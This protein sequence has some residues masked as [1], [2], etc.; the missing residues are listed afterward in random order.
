MLAAALLAFAQ[1]GP[2]VTA[3]ELQDRVR[4]LASDALEGRRAGTRAADRAAG[5]LAGELSRYGLEPAGLA[6]SWFQEFEIELAPEP[7]ACAL[8]VTAREAGAAREWRWEGLGTLACSATASAT[9]PVVSAGYGM[10]LESHGINEF[11]GADVGGKIVLVRRYS[12]F[13]PKAA[14]ELARA[15]EL[16]GKIRAAVEAGA[17]GVVLGTHPNDMARGGEGAIPFDAAPG[18][19]AV[20]VVVVSPEQLAE[21][22][23]LLA[24]GVPVEADL[25][26]E[27]RRPKAVTQNVLGWIRGRSE[28]AVVVGAHYDHLGYGG[29]A[30]LTPGQAAIHNG[31]DD[32]ASGTAL[33]LEVAET[34]AAGPPPE[35]SVLVAFWGAEEEGLLGSDYWVKNPTIPLERVVCNVNLD[36][37]GRLQGGAIT[38]GG[39]GTAAALAA[40][41]E[42]AR[43]QP[44]AQ[45]PELRFELEKGESAATGGSDHMSFQRV[46]I[47]ALFFFSGMHTD[48]HKPSDDWEKLDYGR[49]AVL[50][51]ATAA[52]VRELA[53]APRADLA[54]VPPPA[55]KEERVVRAGERA[56]FGSIPD[57]AAK[58]EGGGMQLAGVSPGGPAEKAGLRAGDVI[59]KV[60]TVAVADIYDF[61]DALVEYR[62]GDTVD[63]QIQRGSESLVVKVTLSG[64]APVQ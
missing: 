58:P 3:A 4:Y 56:S 27:V 60:G 51:G 29:G 49:M 18:T 17:A 24:S 38:I 7:G 32:N 6:G 10:V 46:E 34:L 25:R 1:E 43:P 44:A 22:E 2:S 62:P 23:A 8:Q 37:V 53:L 20:P 47:P 63:V 39:Q 50:A 48:Y 54:W 5:W 28:E 36:M 57:Y 41:V 9:A 33:A 55:P 14:P 15:G 13:G 52:L 11:A 59:K 26:A 61:M 31:A 21:L 16:R 45:E 19:M 12:E 35:R 30:S 40:A 64:R 42:R